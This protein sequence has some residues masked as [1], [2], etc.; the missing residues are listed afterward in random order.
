MSA[1]D[2]G[3]PS[4]RAAAVLEDPHEGALLVTGAPGIGKTHLL[5]ELAGTS[6]LPA[7]TVFVNP[8]E[9]ELALSG[10]GAILAAVDPRAAEFAGRFALRSDDP[11]AVAAAA[12]DIL[13]LL[14]GLRLP[15]TGLLVDDLD[16][17]D[18][19]SRELL[20][21]MAGRLGGTGLRIV[22]TAT[23]VGSRDALAGFPRVRLSPLGQEEALALVLAAGGPDLHEGTARILV[24]HSAGNPATLLAR[25]RTLRA[26]HRSGRKSL[27]FPLPVRRAGR[28]IG[29][30]VLDRLDEE[31]V[32]IVRAL[33]VAPLTHPAA[34][35]E[36]GIA[37]RDELDD[38]VR[39]GIVDEVDPFVR[40]HNPLVRAAVHATLEARQRRQLHAT[41]A[42]ATQA[43]AEVL[44]EYHAAG[45][46]PEGRHAVMLL[47]GATGLL[48][49]GFVGAAVELADAALRR[50]DDLP[51]PADG[52]ALVRLLIRRGEWAL[53]ERYLL[54]LGE[55]D[56]PHR[57]RSTLSLVRLQAEAERTGRVPTASLMAALER[58]GDG[59]PPGAARLLGTVALWHCVR[60]DIPAATEL[61]ALSA[62][63]RARAGDDV[64][65][66]LDAVQEL[67][68]IGG[69][70]GRTAHVGI[71]VDAA[72]ATAPELIAHARAASLCE[73]YDLA[74][75]LYALAV[76]DAEELSPWRDLAAV[77]LAD[78]AVRA[79]R[80]AEAFVAVAR[81]RELQLDDHLL[82]MRVL[83]DAWADIATG[84]PEAA[85]ERLREWVSVPRGVEGLTGAAVHAMLGWL[86]LARGQGQV[87]VRELVHAD[88]LAGD[89]DPGIVRHHPLLI[90]ALTAVGRHDAARAAFD[91][92]E[93]AAHRFPSRWATLA[94]AGA[95]AVVAE[96]DKSGQLFDRALGAF[97]PADSPLER[98]QLL[99]RKGLRLR[100]AGSSGADAVM[101]QARAAFDAMGASA[102]YRDEEPRAASTENPLAGLLTEQEREVARL[103][104]LGLQNKEIAAQLFVSLRTVELRLTHIYRK[105]G[106]RSRSQLVAALS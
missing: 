14:R 4:V 91:R 90:D 29:R 73:A 88:L 39:A 21:F 103:V 68:A 84:H 80:V 63:L 94:T 86:A 72:H 43:H 77:L 1:K 7:V 32:R 70:A 9:H 105:T 48:A 25:L 74:A 2:Q 12:A 62:P 30:Q 99:L 100:A 6:P 11:W 71:P 52:V 95:R 69:G 8:A 56:L 31:G 98:A 85:E 89:V 16:R 92:F 35:A 3:S 36:A 46:E 106:T 60:G 58:F 101:L 54:L 65:R 50:R 87:A 18:A 81:V 66:L 22:A 19:A 47:R 97:T 78:N 96:G 5:H 38:L 24:A 33:A 28:R 76:D 26:A 27:P 57:E 83:L 53:A 93:S 23:R 59:D 55:A 34:L 75:R 13:A 51:D 79:G 42:E 20:G 15:A 104:L 67:A 37:T 40:L 41:L 102:W 45:A 82:R 10:L 49:H 61:L 17:M 44:A 64:L